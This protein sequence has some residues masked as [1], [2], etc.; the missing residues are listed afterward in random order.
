MQNHRPLRSTGRAAAGALLLA[1]CAGSVFAAPPAGKAPA[2]EAALRAAPGRRITDQ[3]ENLK[4]FLLA[5][6]GGGAYLAWA[7]K[8]D[9]RTV[10]LFAASPDGQKYG[11]PIRLSTEAMDLDLGAE[12]GPQA[13]AAADGS[14][15]VTWVA[16]SWKVPPAAMKH[17]GM[18]APG[19][20]GGPPPR[21]GNLNIFLAASH[22]GGKTF[23]PPVKVN[24][25]AAGAEHRFPTVAVDA[26]GAVCV[27]WLDKR[28]QTAEKSDFSRVYFARS[29]DGGRT[30]SANVDATEG[31]ETGICHCCKLA[32]TVDR[33]GGLFIAY[34]NDVNDMRDV[35]L[36]RSSDSGVT[37]TK[38]APVEDVR[39]MIPACPFN[40]PSLALDAREQ[41]HTLWMT[42]GDV[43]GSPSAGPASGAKYK[44]MYRRFDTRSATWS[45]MQFLAEGAHP[46]LAVQPSGTAFVAWEKEGLQLARLPAGDGQP[47]TLRLSAP[48]ASVSFPT[49]ALGTDGRLFAAW[50]QR[51]A[52][53]RWQICVTIVG[54]PRTTAKR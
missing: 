30:F 18:G 10:I 37:W 9:E 11:T 22:D 5:R 44:V 24:D 34:R 54:G 32:L 29:T 51:G 45:G 26:R 48:E 16:G 36:V 42:G 19:G 7:R 20:K 17:S 50:Q 33:R 23:S 47:R 12:S 52:D 1:G 38:P 21:P 53:D 25:D 39:W 31:Q 2:P 6:S 46:R 4:P 3:G 28:K 41:L 35:F 13:A 27:T 8:D 49:L 43:S 15:Y 40:G 14:L